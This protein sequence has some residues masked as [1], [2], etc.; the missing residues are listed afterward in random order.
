VGFLDVGTCGPAYGRNIGRVSPRDPT[1]LLL[2]LLLV[3]VMRI[4]DGW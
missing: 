4:G 3:V 1:A 2:L